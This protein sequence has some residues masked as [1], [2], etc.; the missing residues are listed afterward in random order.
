MIVLHN[1]SASDRISWGVFSWKIKSI[2]LIFK[3]K[4]PVS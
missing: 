2:S 3:W 1:V 4:L